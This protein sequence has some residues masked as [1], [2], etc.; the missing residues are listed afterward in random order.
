MLW[1]LVLK[2]FLRLL[3]VLPARKRK[4]STDYE[5][6]KQIRIQTWE[7]KQLRLTKKL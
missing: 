3:N 1:N 5:S 7:S 2:I 6:S 4:K